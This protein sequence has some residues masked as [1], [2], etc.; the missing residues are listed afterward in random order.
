MIQQGCIRENPP[1]PPAAIPTLKAFVVRRN[2][3][4]LNIV[5]SANCVI[6]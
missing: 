6:L 2:Q 3:M 1:P 5:L 4:P